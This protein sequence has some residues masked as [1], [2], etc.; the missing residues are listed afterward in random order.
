MVDRIAARKWIVLGIVLLVLVTLVM[1]WFIGRF[2]PGTPKT[3]E[4]DIITGRYPGIFNT[5]IQAIE[6]IDINHGETLRVEGVTQ[7]NRY[8]FGNTVPDAAIEDSG[9]SVLEYGAFEL[10]VGE[11]RVI[12]GEALREWYPDFS[13]PD[14][15][16][17]ARFTG[18]KL[19]GKAFA[20]N[21]TVRNP[22]QTDSIDLPD[23]TLW[24]EDLNQYAD[25]IGAGAY[26]LV[27]L[28]RLMNPESTTEDSGEG[29][30]VYNGWT[31]LAPG[32]SREIVVPYYIYRNSFVSKEAFEQIDPERFCLEVNDYDPG[33]RY[34]FWLA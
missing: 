23:L 9:L 18:L 19:P 26:P 2:I 7:G 5:G 32:E 22:S 8:L 29:D 17:I 12:S 1:G 25:E 14:R 27:D 30:V 15:S 33:I 13:L 24:S 3:S 10:S 11:T 34:R 6:D 21:V 31:S 28:V 16:P 4:G 20:V